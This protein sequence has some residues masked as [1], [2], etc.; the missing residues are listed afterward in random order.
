MFEGKDRAR[1]QK[2]RML[3]EFKKNQNLDM[4]EQVYSKSIDIND[5]NNKSESVPSYINQENIIYVPHNS[6]RKLK[7]SQHIKMVTYDIL[8]A[9]KPNIE[10]SE[11]S[12]PKLTNYNK[13][14]LDI[15]SKS[16]KNSA[17]AKDNN[18]E[19]IGNILTIIPENHPYRNMIF[20]YIPKEDVNNWNDKQE[21]NH[22][23][24]IK[25]V[26][27]LF[28]E[29]SNN[30]HI[31]LVDFIVTSNASAKQALVSMLLEEAHNMK[32]VNYKSIGKLI[33]IFGKP[34]T[35]KSH[36]FTN[37]F[38]P[39][40]RSINESKSLKKGAFMGNASLNIDSFT[41]HSQLGLSI[42]KASNNIIQNLGNTNITQNIRE[43]INEWVNVCSLMIDEISQIS[44]AL[45]AQISAAICNIKECKKI[46]GNINMFFFGDFYQMES[47][48]PSLFRSLNECN[49]NKLNTNYGIEVTKGRGLWHQ[50]DYAIFLDEPQRSKDKLYSKIKRRIRNGCCEKEDIAV[51]NRL[52]V[53]QSSLDYARKFREAPFYTTRHYEIDY[54]NEKRL[55]FF[56]LQHN[57][58]I[59]KWQT[60][61]FVNGQQISCESWIYDMLYHE[62]YKFTQ[63]NLKKI[64]RQFLYC[65]GAPY[66]ILETPKQGKYSG[67]VTSNTGIIVGIQLNDNELPVR[68]KNDNCKIRML[69]YPPKVIFLHLHKHTLQQ[70]IIGLDQFPLGT[71]PIFPV[72][73][74]M[75]LYIQKINEKWFNLYNG[76]AYNIPPEIKIKLFGYKLAPAFANTDYGCQGSTQTHIVTNI[77]PGPYAKKN[78]STSAYVILSRAT[79]L[80][81]ILLS[82]PLTE[83]CLRMNPL[84]DLINETCRL[85]IIERNTLSSKKYLIEQLIVQVKDIKFRLGKKFPV[86]EKVPKWVKTKLVYFSNLINNLEK[87]LNIPKQVKTCISCLEICLSDEN[88]PRCFECV[89]DNI[90]PLKAKK[91]VCGN[92]FPWVKKDGITRHGNNCETCSKKYE[93]KKKTEESFSWK[94]KRCLSCNNFTVSKLSKFCSK[95]DPRHILTTKKETEKMNTDRNIINLKLT[96]SKIE[97]KNIQSRRTTNDIKLIDQNKKTLPIISKTN[98]GKTKCY[99][100]FDD[101]VNTNSNINKFNYAKLENPGLNI[102]FLN[103]AVQFVLSIKPLA[104]ILCNE[105]VKNYCKNTTFLSEFEQLEMIEN[106]NR[107]ISPIILAKKNFLFEFETL[108]INM[109]RNPNHTFSASNLA[110]V[111]EVLERDYTYC[112]QWDCSSVVDLFFTLYD[113]FIGQEYF[114]G[115]NNAQAILDSLKII[116]N[117]CTTCNICNITI[118]RELINYFLMVPLE[119]NLD[120]I[121]IPYHEDIRGYL[122]GMCNDLGGNPNPRLIT[123][124]TRKT[125]IKSFSKYVLVKFGRVKLNFEKVT[126]SVTLQEINNVLGYHLKLEAW[127]EHIGATIKS[128]H[129][130]LIRRMEEGCIKISDD[131]ISSYSQNYIE[132]CQLC[133]IALLRRL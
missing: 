46:F 83:Q 2:E 130:V 82:H 133:Y 119:R 40:L 123:V 9:F 107:S 17:N 15:I 111:F 37:I 22:E 122:C 3:D 45:L 20:D 84:P 58:Q 43:K 74:T 110:R 24:N 38:E 67:T 13:E 88:N 108:A 104:D 98:Y 105:Y 114:E 73:E 21:K 115:K 70:K 36:A 116:M 60:P 30:N 86:V 94:R 34:G 65:E 23:N 66:K 76:P 32:L 89:K 85:K 81:G 26:E 18:T 90:P 91:C 126:F 27:F 62:R 97:S 102:C 87:L 39:Y 56:A 96:K 127:V 6:I 100:N 19:K 77:L 57:K 16:W 79:S 31:R 53:Q 68:N 99:K 75:T 80:D 131:N 117:E 48:S 132:S 92:T 112:D 109:I 33:G 54:V 93:T 128:G 49:V 61:I 8:K 124:A 118:E 113:A 125:E 42:A 55:T 41:L 103:S 7:I 47:I 28:T 50:L 44:G 51:L 25:F 1:R 69:M 29:Y 121:F 4:S 10:N 95:C 63:K 35:G 52:T 72:Y 64:G 78:S 101:L 71:V 11:V 106:P 120:N 5:V 14:S 59:I 12:F 129:Y